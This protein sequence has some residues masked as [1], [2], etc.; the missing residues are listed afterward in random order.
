MPGAS[1]IMKLKVLLPFLYLTI[2]FF[3]AFFIFG[4]PGILYNIYRSKEE[5]RLLD[6]V[7]KSYI[8]IEEMTREYYRLVEMKTPN[9]AFLIEQGRKLQDVL[10]FKIDEERKEIYPQDLLI[11]QEKKLFFSI[12][13]IAIV[14]LLSGYIGLFL[15]TY[16]A[17]KKTQARQENEGFIE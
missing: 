3:V 8:E 10:V 16:I 2:A 9:Q 15:I 1:E 4:K 14:V 17:K 12:G 5:V 6:T 13:F 7:W 11:E